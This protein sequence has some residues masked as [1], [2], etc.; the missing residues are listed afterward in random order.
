MLS[1][2]INEYS[3]NPQN[4]KNT[5][6]RNSFLSI[7]IVLPTLEYHREYFKKRNRHLLQNLGRGWTWFLKK[8]QTEKSH[9]TAPFKDTDHALTYLLTRD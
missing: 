4:G 6:K 5:E 1:F 8:P 2:F 3:Y 9:A 7:R